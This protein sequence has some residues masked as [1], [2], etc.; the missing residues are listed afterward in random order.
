MT[1]NILYYLQRELDNA[2]QT[3]GYCESNIEIYKRGKNSCRSDARE[4]REYYDNKIIDSERT[5]NDKL[6][7]VA[8]L[9]KLISEQK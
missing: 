7:D 9:K 4:T 1:K 2:L 8:V 3:I 5:M 6:E